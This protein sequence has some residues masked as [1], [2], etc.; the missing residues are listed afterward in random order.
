MEE[1]AQ[2]MKDQ[3]CDEMWEAWGQ[4]EM[5]T[6]GKLPWE[7]AGSFEHC[8]AHHVQVADGGYMLQTISHGSRGVDS[9]DTGAASI[10]RCM[11]SVTI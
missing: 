2:R 7:M 3:M 10:G 9:A 11:E 8:G 1:E 6:V 5:A 4:R